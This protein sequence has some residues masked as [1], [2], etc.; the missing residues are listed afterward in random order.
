MRI[1]DQLGENTHLGNITLS[2]CNVFFRVAKYDYID[3]VSDARKQ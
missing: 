2:N 3:Y 1:S